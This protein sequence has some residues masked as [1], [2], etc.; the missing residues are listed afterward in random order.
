[1]HSIQIQD[2]S[3]IK[4]WSVSRSKAW[5][6]GGIS[7]KYL[8]LKFLLK[9]R[10][11]PYYLGKESFNIQV[12][13]VEQHPE[14]STLLGLTRAAKNSSGSQQHFF[15]AEFLV[16]VNILLVSAG[17][18]AEIGPRPGY[19]ARFVPIMIHTPGTIPF[20][21][22]RHITLPTLYYEIWF[23]NCGGFCVRGL[24]T[25]FQLP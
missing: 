25:I 17:T 18:R 22:V 1:M 7:H 9:I 6:M 12:Q 16:P 11:L 23:W 13:E 19:L 8:E 3:S 10:S 21:S 20:H 4:V 14:T 15:G 2:P 5:S 24:L